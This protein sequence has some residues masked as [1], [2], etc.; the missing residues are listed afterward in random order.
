MWRSFC[1]PV[2][3]DTRRRSLKSV[4]VIKSARTPG[5]AGFSPGRGRRVHTAPFHSS[6]FPK[7]AKK[8]LKWGVLVSLLFSVWLIPRA[9]RGDGGPNQYWDIPPGPSSPNG[10]WDLT[11]PF[12]SSSATGGGTLTAWQNGSDAVFAASNLEA[13][14][15]YTVT[16][17]ENV[18]VGDL[19]YIGG[20]LGSTLQIAGGNTITTENS[21]M[22]VAVDFGTTLVVAPSIV[23]DANLVLQGGILVL[24]GANTY[25]GGTIISTGTLQLGTGAFNRLNRRRRGQQRYLQHRQC[26]HRRDHVDHQ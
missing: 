15:N 19:S 21:T 2:D 14:G 25:G 20:A 7:A 9:A 3:A 4:S 10:L 17:A 11:S 12:W 8:G 5:G 26:E 23:G 13:T 1:L 16:L 6:T 22:N 18:I 24:T